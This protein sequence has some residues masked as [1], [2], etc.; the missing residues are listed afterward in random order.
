MT[1]G[2]VVNDHGDGFRP[3]DLGLPIIS[4]KDRII[5]NANHAVRRAKT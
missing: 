4:G 3:Q 1:D 2:Y 5:S